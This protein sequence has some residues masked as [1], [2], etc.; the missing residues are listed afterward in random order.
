M[1]RPRHARAG[2]EA[3]RLPDPDRVRPGRARGDGGDGRLVG[4]EGGL[5]DGTPDGAGIG[6]IGAVYA[7]EAHAV[8]WRRAE[9][10]REGRG[11]GGAGG[12]GGGR[13]GRI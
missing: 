9:A 11:G 12:G 1:D 4:G 13:G 8:L 5:A 3:A 7:R 6:P 10:D 2:G